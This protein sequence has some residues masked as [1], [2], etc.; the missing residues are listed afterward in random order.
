ME[1]NLID[2]AVTSDVRG[3][4]PSFENWSDTIRTYAGFSV[5]IC[6]RGVAR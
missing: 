1:L 4:V 2:P 6:R 3:G 5:L